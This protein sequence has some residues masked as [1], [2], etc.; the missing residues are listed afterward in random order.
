MSEQVVWLNGAFLPESEAH[1]GVGDRGF[2]LGD[3]CFETV[4]CYAGTLFK[5]SEHLDRLR[6]SLDVAGIR[7]SR[8]MEKIAAAAG[9]LPSRAGLRD[10]RVRITISRGTDCEVYPSEVSDSTVLITA[11]HQ[12]PVPKEA[13][14]QGWKATICRDLIHPGSAI[15]IRAKSVS[16]LWLVM[17][18]ADADREGVD[19]A[20]MRGPDGGIVEG[21]RSNIFVVRG[22]EVVTPSTSS[23]ALPGITRAE[24]LQIAF[25]LGLATTERRLP[26]E[27]LLSADECFLSKTTTGPVPITS[28]DGQAIG[29]GKPG[30]VTLR[31]ADEY[32]KVVQSVCGPQARVRGL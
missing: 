18:A 21:T 26:V 32:E 27:D 29:S 23:G 24:I 7:C 17:A 8:P 10:A 28:V 12:P 6:V 19:E 25:R 4:S 3:G 15:W 30:D 31:L 11:V 5:L 16:R 13:F 2:L 9:M 20:F 14:E 1:I 22:G